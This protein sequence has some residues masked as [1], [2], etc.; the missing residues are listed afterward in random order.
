MR[1]REDVER[2]LRRRVRRVVEA[3]SAGSTSGEGPRQHSYGGKRIQ[4]DVASLRKYGF[5]APN[6]EERRHLADAYRAIKRPLLKTALGDDPFTARRNLLMVASAVPG[7]GKTFTCLNLCLSLA[8]ERDWTVVL[9]D[10]D[11]PKRDMT[12]FF[13]AERQPGLLELLRGQATSFDRLVMPTNVP[14]LSFLP[15]GA[16]DRNATE[17]LSSARMSALCDEIALD[18]PRRLVVFDSSP[19]LYT[20]EAPALASQV[21]QIAMVVRADST[22][23][24]AVLAALGK[25]DDT[26]AVNLVLNDAVEGETLY[27]GYYPYGYG[28]GVRDARTD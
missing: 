5:F 13:R 11:S 15:S 3:G 1:R 7:E 26:K 27:Y 16:P 21:A 23:Q 2:T 25:L 18:D 6:M 14:S 8:K 12:R 17:L 19:L 28:Y 10:G 4:M 20:S 9:V 24:Q 22:P